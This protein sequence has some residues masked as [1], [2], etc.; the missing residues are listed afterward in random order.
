MLCGELKKAGKSTGNPPYGFKVSIQD[1]KTLVS[2]DDEQ[3]VFGKVRELR[4][5][6]YTW[7]QVAD[8][9]NK[10]SSTRRGNAWTINS[11]YGTFN[12]KLK[13]S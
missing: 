3:R 10:F 8:E 2:C 1:G 5:W 7:E 12:K 6:R 13:A 4:G 11:V 9:L